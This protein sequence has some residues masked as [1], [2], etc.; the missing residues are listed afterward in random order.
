MDR[1][2]LGRY[3]S[4]GEYGRDAIAALR[5]IE[6]REMGYAGGNDGETT[7]DTSSAVASKREL[8]AAEESGGCSW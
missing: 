6:E 2:L 8:R 4:S 7:D 5:A 1:P 3:A